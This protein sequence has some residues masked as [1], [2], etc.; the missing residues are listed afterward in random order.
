MKL[1]KLNLLFNLNLAFLGKLFGG[2]DNEQSNNT[3][4][5]K[6]RAKKKDD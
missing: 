5:P 2:G 3:S 6:R 1:N 4:K